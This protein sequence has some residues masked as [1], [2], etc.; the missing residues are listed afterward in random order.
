M[1]KIIG[2]TIN[3]CYYSTMISMDERFLDAGKTAN[4]RDLYGVTGIIEDE[5]EDI[6][7]IIFDETFE[8]VHAEDLPN[9]D[10]NHYDSD[11]NAQY[12]AKRV[13]AFRKT[14]KGKV[15]A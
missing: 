11:R 2:K 12:L 14:M 3:G 9:F 6:C 7:L 13:A 10:V 5:P 15:L 8:I 1:Q 4:E